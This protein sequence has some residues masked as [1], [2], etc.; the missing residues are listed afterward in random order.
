MLTLITRLCR[1]AL[2]LR[3][4]VCSPRWTQPQVDAIRRGE[5]CGW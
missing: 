5:W 3:Y 4:V 1:E 2:A